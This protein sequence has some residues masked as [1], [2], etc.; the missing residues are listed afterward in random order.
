MVEFAW[1]QKVSP[2]WQPGEG[3]DVSKIGDIPDIRIENLALSQ[4][5]LSCLASANIFTLRELFAAREPDLK[6]IRGFGKQSLDEVQ[7]LFS[8]SGVRYEF[9]KL[10]PSALIRQYKEAT[11]HF[12]RAIDLLDDEDDYD[13]F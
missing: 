2:R 8:S 12:E 10:I 1:R 11:G 7:H 5:T 13:D 4:K 9:K 3:F 6:S